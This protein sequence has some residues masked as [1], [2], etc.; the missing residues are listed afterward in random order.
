MV[1]EHQKEVVIKGLDIPFWDLVVFLIKLSLASIPALFILGVV[2]MVLGMIFG[3]VF[4]PM[5][6]R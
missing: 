2:Y 5:M 1:E 4:L 6:P 3:A